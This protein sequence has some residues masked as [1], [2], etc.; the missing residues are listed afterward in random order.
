MVSW[1]QPAAEQLPPIPSSESVVNDMKHRMQPF[2]ET[3]RSIFSA[4]DPSSKAWSNHLP[5]WPTQG[6]DGH[7]ARGR[8]TLAGDAAHPMTPHRGQGLNNAISDC[9]ELLKQFEAMS[10]RSLGA[11][12]EAVARYEKEMWERGH[13]AVV[14]SLE[15][16]LAVHDW[17]MLSESPIFREGVTKAKAQRMGASEG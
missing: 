8:V 11:L 5:Y 12:K 4:I 6:W 2:T 13:D 9:A 7:T 14:S 16:S 10:E 1:I 17:E 15:N 3:F